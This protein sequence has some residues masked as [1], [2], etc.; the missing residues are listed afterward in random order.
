VAQWIYDRPPDK[1]DV[2][3]HLVAEKLSQLDERWLIRWGY[4]YSPDRGKEP[5]REGDFLVF[6]PSGE[7]LV[8]EVKAGHLR[9]FALTGNWEHEER[10]NPWTQLLGEWGAV[11]TRM[12]NRSRSGDVPFVGKALCLPNCNFLD[13]DR[14][15]GPVTRECLVGGTDLDDFPSWWNTYARQTRPRISPDEARKV[16]MDSWCTGLKPKQ[17]KFFMRETDKIIL[18]HIEHEYEILDMLFENQQILVEGGPGTG[19]TFLALEQAKRLASADGGNRVLFLCYNLALADLLGEFVR[20]NPPESGEI[21]VNSWEA[22]TTEILDEAGLAGTAPEDY[23][24]RQTFFH[25]EI[26][27]LILEL[28]RDGRIRPVYDALVVDEG[29]DHDTRFPE[30]LSAPD[31]PGWW[32]LYMQL[33]KSGSAGRM[34]VFYDTAQR[35]SFRNPEYFDPADLI[36]VFS[37][38]AHVQLLHTVRYTRPIFEFLSNLDG[39]GVQGL[40]AS[41][42]APDYL[43]EGPEVEIHKV[44]SDATTE[45]VEG[46]VARWVASGLCRPEEILVLGLRS[47]RVSS[48]LGNCVKLSAWPLVD[49]QLDSVRGTIPYLSIHKAKGLD[50][51]AVILI[52]LAPFEDLVGDGADSFQ[53]AYF[54]G[55]SRARQLLAVVHRV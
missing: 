5:E 46:I 6:A 22:L 12:Q 19:K 13:G 3:E 7:V 38:P 17:V 2:T 50:R 32:G 28:I 41:M 35:P 36:R 23:E 14:F 40:V 11:L 34:T 9:Q 21:V 54:M 43:P 55:A 37:Q 47:D 31:H 45:C 26:P 33:V 18:R 53:E 29:Q 49:Y 48:S 16:F 44:D 51:L 25:E 4:Y 42:H 8:L 39:D 1:A 52:D 10:D 20:R 27:G 30:A 24:D 15:R